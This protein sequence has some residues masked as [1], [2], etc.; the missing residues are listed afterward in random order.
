MEKRNQK[1]GAAGH[2]TRVQLRSGIEH[3]WTAELIAF[4]VH[5]FP[6]APKDPPQTLPAK[7]LVSPIP[8]SSLK[9]QIG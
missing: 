4:Y 2:S 5:R 7:L 8:T 6:R 3:L 9:L 1:T